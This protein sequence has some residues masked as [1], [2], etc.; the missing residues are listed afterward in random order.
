MFVCEVPGQLSRIS[1]QSPCVNA[2]NSPLQQLVSS[3]SF[4]R[5][6]LAVISAKCLFTMFS[7]RS[8]AILLN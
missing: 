6:V 1:I 3:P 4:D 7:N 8:D 2:R 5:K